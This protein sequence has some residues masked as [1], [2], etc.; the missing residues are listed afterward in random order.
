MTVTEYTLPAQTT[1]GSFG[2]R[3]RD[4]KISVAFYTRFLGF[5]LLEPVANGVAR[6]GAG[7]HPILHL[8]ETPDAPRPSASSA[9][10]YHAAI[11]LPT[12]A[13]LAR[14]VRHLI[15]RNIEFGYADHLVS[16]A[17]YINDVEG[18]GLEIYR[19]RPRSEWKWQNGTVQ[20]ANAQIDFDSLFASIEGDP[21]WREM[22][23]GTTLGHMHLKVGDIQLANDFYHKLMGFDIM[24]TWTGALFM[25]AGGYHHH[26]GLNTWHS[27]GAGKTPNTVTGLNHFDVLL[28]SEEDRARLVERLAGA[29]VRTEQNGAYITAY[30]PWDNAIRIGVNNAISS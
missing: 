27:R 12:R 22:P 11:L 6:L 21:T 14:F 30:D 7:G 24:A 1:L 3:V 13:D 20:M 19:D 23:A 28:P 26:L 4:L 2:L 16:E 29:G 5:Q 17:F 25:S 9:G 15:E 18:N 10:L 8:L